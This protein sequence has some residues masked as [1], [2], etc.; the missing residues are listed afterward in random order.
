MSEQTQPTGP[1]RRTGFTRSRSHRAVGGVCGGLGRYFDLDPVVFRVPLAVLSVISGLGLVL[2]GLAWLAVPPEDGESGLRKLMSGRVEGGCLS[3][4]VL[5][6]VGCGLFLA[7]LD[8]GSTVFALVLS[9]AVLGAAHWSQQRRSSPSGAC[10]APVAVAEAPPE[11]QAPPVPSAPPWWRDPPE[12]RAGTPSDGGRERKRRQRRSLGGPVFL[13]AVAAALLG[14]SGTWDSRP[15]G[16]AL[17]VGLACAL[18]VFALGAAV[19]VFH[20]RR[21]AGT[22]AAVVVTAAALAGTTLVPQDMGTDWRDTA[23]APG[24]VPDTAAEYRLNA[25]RAELDLGGLRLKK[26]ET[27][28]TGVEAHAAAVTVLVPHDVRVEVDARTSAG[29]I[30]VPL[31]TAPG[32]PVVFA[33]S[34]GLGR[35]VHRTLEPLDDVTARGTVDLRL[36]VGVGRAEIVRLLPSGER[37]EG[38][39]AS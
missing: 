22:L 15:L 17:A 3:A 21:G 19:T 13:T 2:Y 34:R 32:G 1:A 25:G 18:A 27:V 35:A 5:A 37:A 30:R 31:R 36:R 10:A 39:R 24:S 9:G 8:R 11:T 28:T 29:A 16:T 12:K 7:R 20:G 14:T 33:D 6:L 23:W 38:S 4:V 26:G